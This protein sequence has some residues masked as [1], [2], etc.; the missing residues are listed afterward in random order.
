MERSRE[1]QKEILLVPLGKVLTDVLE[2]IA[3]AVRK[4]FG[5][6]VRIGRSEEPDNATYSDARRQYDADQLLSLMLGRKREMLAAV[7]G[8]VDADIFSGEKSFVFGV[9]APERGAAVL[10][11]SRLREEFY[12]KNAKRELFLRRAVSEA[13]YQIGSA[14]GVPPCQHKQCVMYPSASLW[15]LDEKGQAFC[16][17]SR[18]GL[19]DKLSVRTRAAL[20]AESQGAKASEAPGTEEEIDPAPAGE[21]MADS[22]PAAMPASRATDGEPYDEN[23]IPADVLEPEVAAAEETAMHVAEETPDE[24]LDADTRDRQ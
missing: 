9:H 19:E 17:D 18:Q 8:I 20:R 22:G 5:L 6:H 7:L 2:E 12:K 10:A 15:R 1:Q 16:P 4:T 14:I 13:I 3:V 11:L 23:Q 21:I 24:P